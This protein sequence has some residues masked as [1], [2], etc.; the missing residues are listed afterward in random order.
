MGRRERVGGDS[1]RGGGERRRRRKSPSLEKTLL[2]NHKEE[3]KVEAFSAF[4]SLFLLMRVALPGSAPRLRTP[5]HTLRPVLRAR[6]SYLLVSL[7]KARK[8]RRRCGDEENLIRLSN[9]LASLCFFFLF[10]EASKDKEVALSPLTTALIQK[11]T[12]SRSI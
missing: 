3:K 1:G 10:F 9:R 12:R 2:I 7:S 11:L 5:L 8:R 6:P 4:L